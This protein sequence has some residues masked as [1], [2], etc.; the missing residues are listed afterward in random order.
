[1]SDCPLWEIQVNNE[2]IKARYATDKLRGKTTRIL[3]N[4]IFTLENAQAA[5]HN[6]RGAVVEERIDYLLDTLNAFVAELN[7]E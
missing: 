7:D 3:L 5:H 6:N 4:A 1:M 2:L